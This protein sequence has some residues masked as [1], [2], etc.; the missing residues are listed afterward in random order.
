MW[1]LLF[2]PMF[3]LVSSRCSCFCHHQTHACQVKFQLGPLTRVLKEKTQQVVALSP[4]RCTAAAH[5]VSEED[6]STAADKFR[7]K[8]YI[9]D[10]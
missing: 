7:C 5:C 4:W 9:C 2:L 6:G 1:K 3:V 8:L 10:R